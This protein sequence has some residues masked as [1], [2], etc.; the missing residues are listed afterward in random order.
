M[1]VTCITPSTPDRVVFNE[2]IK[3]IFEAQDYADKEHIMLL[4]PG[5]IGDKR[6]QCISYGTGEIIL[7]LDSDDIY[8]PDWVSRSV[9][10]LL[11]SNAD[12]VGLRSAY[13]Y[14]ENN[15]LM[16]YNYHGGQPYTIGAAMCYKRN[17]WERGQFQSVSTGE[18]LLF[19]SGK[20]IVCHDYKEGFA[21]IIHDNNTCSHKALTVKEMRAIPLSTAPDIL[22]KYYPILLPSRLVL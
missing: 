7:H 15:R 22:K 9:N 18:D 19:C 12:M 21:A 3:Q 16:D 11:Q 17:A 14:V 5:T 8:A 2:R 6:N 20:R 10:A 4:S 1:K 13:F